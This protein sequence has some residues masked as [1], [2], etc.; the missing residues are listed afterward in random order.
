[1]AG[2]TERQRR[3]CE[4]YAA[5]PNATAAAK[6]AGYSEKSAHSIGQENL[7][8]PEICEYIRQLQKSA[9]AGRIASMRE[10]KEY[11]TT[12]MNS[13]RE[14][15]RPPESVRTACKSRWRVSPPSPCHKRRAR[16]CRRDGRQRCD[17][18]RPANAQRGRLSGAGDGGQRR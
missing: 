17:D 1:M 15:H 8:K 9:E 13:S 14:N 6:A 7:K 3:F 10:I 5:D 4:Y 16:F 18:I 11:W 2:L 12:T